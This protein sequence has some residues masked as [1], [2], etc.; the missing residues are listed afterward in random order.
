[1]SS[2]LSV[3]TFLDLVELEKNFCKKHIEI[4]VCTSMSWDTD[5]NPM[6]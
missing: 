5:L 3:V 1:M 4:I 2:R 6:F